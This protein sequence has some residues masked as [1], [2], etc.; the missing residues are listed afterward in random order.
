METEKNLKEKD[1]SINNNNNLYETVKMFDK[2]DQMISRLIY[3]AKIQEGRVSDKST[4]EALVNGLSKEIK[5]F[6]GKKEKFY[7]INLVLEAVYCIVLIEV[8]FFLTIKAKASDVF[9]YLRYLNQKIQTKTS[10]QLEATVLAFLEHVLV[11]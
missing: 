7:C 11:F 2:V 3:V 6:F 1:N 8:N 5:D 4:R 10:V 9:N